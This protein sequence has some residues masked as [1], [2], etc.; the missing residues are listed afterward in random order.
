MKW[1]RETRVRPIRSEEELANLAEVAFL[2]AK[3]KRTV[4]V[5]HTIVLIQVTLS[6]IQ[7]HTHHN[8]GF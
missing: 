1:F 3:P 2:L 7:K 5:L 4:Q 6:N 8:D